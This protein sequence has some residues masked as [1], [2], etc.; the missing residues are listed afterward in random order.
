MRT[1]PILLFLQQFQA[2]YINGLKL[3]KQSGGCSYG[4]V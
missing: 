1:K 4:D 3:G 2:I